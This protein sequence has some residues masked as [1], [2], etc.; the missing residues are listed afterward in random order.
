[1]RQR[2]TEALDA[3]V[4]NS[5]LANPPAIV[6]QVH[7]T[8]P[9]PQQGGPVFSTSFTNYIKKAENGIRSGFRH[10]KWFP[11]PDPN[12]KFNVIAYGHR[13]L[14]GENFDAGITEEQAHQMMMK[15]LFDAWHRADKWLRA[16]YSKGMNAIPRQSQEILTDFAYNPGSLGTF[17]KFVDAVMKGDMEGMQREYKRSF[18]NGAGERKEMG[19]N[20]LFA[21]LFFNGNG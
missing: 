5:P 20:A 12:G 9:S 17:P 2:L 13:V 6:F 15:D 1:M 16:K 19:R 10:G 3:N 11:I 7:Q 14:P 4:L 18:V 8:P 21:Q